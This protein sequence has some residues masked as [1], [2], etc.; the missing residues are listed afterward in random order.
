MLPKG[1]LK[2]NDDK[3]DAGTANARKEFEKLVEQEE[4]RQGGGQ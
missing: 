4:K 2:G 3:E 1:M